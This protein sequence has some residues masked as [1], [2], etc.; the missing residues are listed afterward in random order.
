MY[1]GELKG[2]NMNIIVKNVTD[3]VEMQCAWQ[4][5]EDYSQENP[6]ISSGVKQNVYE[7]EITSNKSVVVT[8]S[9][10]AGN[11]KAYQAVVT[12][13]HENILLT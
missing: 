8:V 1:G 13:K 2:N 10:Y 9:C 11:M 5:I 4:S 6:K 3:V 7:Y 12:T